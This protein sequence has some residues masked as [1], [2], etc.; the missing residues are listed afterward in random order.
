[1]DSAYEVPLLAFVTPQGEGP[2]SVERFSLDI[3][4][5]W[6]PESVQ[7]F[8]SIAQQCHVCTI[9]Q[10]W[11]GS[12]VIAALTASAYGRPHGSVSAT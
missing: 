2:H 8:V 9:G 7:F 6:T 3:A 12:E 5:T 4:R 10:G 11:T 1:M